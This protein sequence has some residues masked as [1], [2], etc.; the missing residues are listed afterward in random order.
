MSIRPFHKFEAAFTVSVA[1]SSSRSGGS[2]CESAVRSSGSCCESAVRSGGSCC[3][4]AVRA[5][6]MGSLGWVDCKWCDEPV[7]N[8]YLMDGGPGGLCD[9]CWDNMMLGFRPPRWPHALPRCSMWLCLVFATPQQEA[10]GTDFPVGVR[11]VL[12]EFLVAWWM[13]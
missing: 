8:P 3:E 12:A 7:F 5:S 6:P 1:T 4:S 13:P 9:K 11:R 2:S 10:A